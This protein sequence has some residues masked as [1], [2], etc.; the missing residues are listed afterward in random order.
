MKDKNLSPGKSPQAAGKRFPVLF[1]WMT[2]FFF[3]VLAKQ[4]LENSILIS[5][6]ITALPLS[7]LSVSGALLFLREGLAETQ[8]WHLPGDHEGILTGIVLGKP[9]LSPAAA[10]GQL[11]GQTR[12]A[13]GA[14]N[15]AFHFLFRVEA[16]RLQ[17]L[18]GDVCVCVGWVCRRTS[19]Q[20]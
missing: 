3:N 2:F 10:S 4:M 6:L 8:R 15:L 12:E 7:S 14:Q 13:E 20:G 11:T 19:T 17:C 9:T 16:L 18:K 5:I 1:I